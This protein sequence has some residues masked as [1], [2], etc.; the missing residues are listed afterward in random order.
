MTKTI[1]IAS[2]LAFSKEKIQAAAPGYVVVVDGK[3]DYQDSDVEIMI[4][5]AKQA[6][7]ILQAPN[8]LKWIQST[9]AGVNYFDLDLLKTHDVVLTNNSGMHA[10]LMSE[11]V[12]GA[13]IAYNRDFKRT[14]DQQHERVYEQYYSTG[15]AGK[16]MLIVGTGHIGQTLASYAAVM[17]MTVDGINTTGHAVASF[18]RTYPIQDLKDVVGHYDIVVNILP[19]T[20][21]TE[22][23][24][25]ADVFRQFKDGAVFVNIGRGDSVVE[26]DLQMALKANIAY[27]ILDVYRN[28]PLQPNSAWYDLPNVFMSPHISG[29]LTH[30]AD[31]ILDDYFLPN[32]KAYLE[33]GQPTQHVVDLDKGY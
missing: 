18:E 29:W 8:R 31:H 7:R 28:E 25:D 9:S 19:L 20:A 4:G 27:S 26:A 32:L 1:L 21:Q 14:V 6:V 10:T 23:L 30:E 3:D 5:G 15:L 13:L 2:G 16:S 11:F 12:I 24:Y 17:G 33:N 22:D